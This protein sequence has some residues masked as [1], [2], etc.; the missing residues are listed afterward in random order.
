MAS[1]AGTCG[2]LSLTGYMVCLKIACS[3]D[4]LSQIP[5]PNTHQNAADYFVA[6]RTATLVILLKMAEVYG[7]GI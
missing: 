2:P 5:M 7:E 3:F 4:E 1:L 6:Q